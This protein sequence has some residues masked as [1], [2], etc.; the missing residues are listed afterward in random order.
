MKVS[1]MAAAI[2]LAAA[3]P[4]MAGGGHCDEDIAAVDKALAAAKLSDAD[5][6][7]VKAARASAEEA[8]TAKKSEECDKA[9]EPAQKLL[10]INDKHGH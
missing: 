8:H 7:T 4:A 5:L 1:L 6:A 3:V 9:L 10:G 2:L